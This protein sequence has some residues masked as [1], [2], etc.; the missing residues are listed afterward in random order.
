MA[1]TNTN[2]NLSQTASLWDNAPYIKN[3]AIFIAD[4]HFMPLDMPLNEKGRDASQALLAYFENLNNNP[5]T[6]PSQIFLMGDIAH[7]LLGGVDSS[8]R[9]NHA[10]L[11]HIES[12]SQ[13]SQIWWFEGNHDFGLKA[14]FKGLPCLESVYLIPRTEQPKAFIYESQ[15]TKKH[16]LLAHGDILLTEQYEFYIRL[17]NTRYL[18][19]LI[20]LLDNVT[21]GNLYHSIAKKVNHNTIRVGK[22]SME[23]FAPMRINAYRTYMQH[24]IQGKMQDIDVIIEGH[25]HIGK[26]YKGNNDETLYVSLP[27]FYVSRSIFDIKSIFHNTSFAQ[28]E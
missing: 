18:R 21:F 9:A 3:D 1:Y 16:L 5:H 25:F 26:T 17:M 28:G 19:F 13:K 8:H 10:L 15:N 20:Y 4:S 6:I 27:S 24:I 7:L 11:A 12:L 23:H 22:V 2:E 14:S